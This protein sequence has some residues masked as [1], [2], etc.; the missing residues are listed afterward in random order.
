MTTDHTQPT[1]LPSALSEYVAAAA[2]CIVAALM[3]LHAAPVLAQ[4]TE[5]VIRPWDCLTYSVAEGSPFG[6]P[7]PPPGCILP[8]V[9]FPTGIARAIALPEAPTGLT[10]TVSGRTVFLNWTPSRSGGT[11]TSYLVQAGSAS[12]SADMVRAS[13]ESVAPTLTATNVPDGKYFFRVLAQSESGASVASNEIFV[14]MGG[15]NRFTKLCAVPTPPASTQLT[16]TQFTETDGTPKVRFEWRAGEEQDCQA[17]SPVTVGY[18]IEYGLSPGAADGHLELPIGSLGGRTTY[19]ISLAG[20]SGTFYIR[21]RGVNGFG[22]GAA[23]N[24][25]V[26][27]VGGVCSGAPTPP[28]NLTATSAGSTVAIRWAEVSPL[29]NRPTSYTGAFSSPTRGGGAVGIGGPLT[30]L[31]GEVFGLYRTTGVPSGTYVWQISAN[32]ACGRSAPTAVT[33]VVSGP[34]VPVRVSGVYSWRGAP[35]DGGNWSTLI[36]ARANDA[37]YGTTTSGGPVNPRCVANRDGCGIV[38]RISGTGALT[39]LHAFGSQIVSASTG[40]P[41]MYPFGAPVEAADGS[42]W[43]TTTG[44]EPGRFGAGAAVLYKLSH[45]G[46]SMRFISELGGPS[47]SAPMQASDGT[48]YGTTVDNGPGTCSWRQT[49]CTPTSGSGTIFKV[50]SDGTGFTYIHTFTGA[51]GSKPYGGL[52]QA[53]DGTLWGTTSAGGTSDLGTIYKIVGGVFST[54][55]SFRGGS[56]GANPAQSAM[57]QAS[58]GNLFGTTQFGGSNINQGTIFRL[59]PTTRAVT[60]LHAFTGHQQVTGDDE[61]TTA[62]DGLQPV[63]TPIEGPDGRL[64]GVAGGGGALGGGVAYSIKKDGSEYTQ[65]YAFS[66]GPESGG[67]TTTLIMT[68]DGNF[69]GT[70]QY[71]GGFNWGAIFQMTRPQ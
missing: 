46:S 53:T 42:F 10:A 28:A 3:V 7:V 70:G 45:D 17:F 31:A 5:E 8:A 21:V 35:G 32:N 68:P 64:Y 30:T 59:N 2:R 4:S 40:N 58:D 41:A 67:L 1:P 71:G 65:L 61:P 13:T 49:V 63:G 26:L 62:Q 22:P 15:A 11:P 54:V 44:Q 48:I 24:E 60:I 37:G 50:N 18:W 69:Y 19:T 20:I 47:Y 43:G 27:N 34:G 9:P 25:V 55:Y 38:Y 51:N 56:D 57:I 16:S 12:G 23:S 36:L 66:G 14:Q 52:M 29:R 6:R 39:I 33:V